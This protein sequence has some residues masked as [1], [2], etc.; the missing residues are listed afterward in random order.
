MCGNKII[1]RGG[2]NLKVFKLRLQKESFFQNFLIV[3]LQEC[4]GLRVNIGDLKI[5]KIGI[6]S[7]KIGITFTEVRKIGII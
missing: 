4:G 6:I 1:P 2:K 5:I 3:R 7:T